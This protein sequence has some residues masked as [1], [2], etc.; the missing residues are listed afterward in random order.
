VATP[1]TFTFRLEKLLKVRILR[2]QQA[3]AEVIAARVALQREEHKLAQLH[4]EA[5]T[6]VEDM[7]P[8]PTKPFIPHERLAWEH[9]LKQK[10]Q[11]IEIQKPR[12]PAAEQFLRD[13]QQILTQRGIEVKALEKLKE[14]KQEEH[15]LELLREQAIFLD[16]LSSQQYI[17]QEAER[18]L[19][20]AE[21]EEGW[22][23]EDAE[24]VT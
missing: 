18:A 2:E 9:K 13:K 8:G 24:A 11:E 3:Q 20:A 15:R 21:A 14:K 5:D 6:I 23:E 7:T 16:D 19:R 10:K 22:L 17:R 12:I 1:R 4:T